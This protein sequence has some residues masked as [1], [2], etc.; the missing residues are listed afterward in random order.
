MEE[1]SYLKR[2]MGTGLVT[3]RKEWALHPI[4]CR[5]YLCG[6]YV[7]PSGIEKVSYD[8]TDENG[9]SGRREVNVGDCCLS[10]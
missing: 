10:S 6:N 5:C 8:W 2:L 7:D 4:M 1:R 3:T 9:R